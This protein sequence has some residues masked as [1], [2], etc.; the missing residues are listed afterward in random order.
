MNV[1]TDILHVTSSGAIAA[2][3]REV[4]LTTLNANC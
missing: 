4:T 3:E 1:K 2:S